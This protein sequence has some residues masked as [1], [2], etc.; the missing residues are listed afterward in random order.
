MHINA[1]G[2]CCRQWDPRQSRHEGAIHSQ[3]SLASLSGRTVLEQSQDAGWQLALHGEAGQTVNTWDTM[4]NHW[5][6]DYDD[7]L[8]P[9][10]V[11]ENATRL[12]ERFTYSDTSDLNQ[13]GRLVRHDD[14]AGSQ[15]I[16]SYSLSGQ[17]RSETRHFLAALD[18]PDWPDAVLEPGDGATTSYIHGPLQQVLIQ[19]DALGNQQSF[20]FNL[21]G[22][23]KR[24][25]LRLVD[26][27]ERPL[28]TDARYNAFGQIESQTAGNGVVSRCEYEHSTGRLS[29]LVA[30]RPGRSVLQD[31]R[32]DY[33]PVGN[34]LKIEDRS[35]P[36]S[37]FANQ[38]VEPVS[39][40]VYDSLY[41]LI[42]A[43]GREA[44]G[45]VLGPGLPELAP[46]PGDTS[47]LLNYRQHYDYDASGNL[48]EL[49]H[50]GQQSY[51]REMAVATDSN[52]AVP[53]P[54]DPL[55]AFDSNGNL[56][57]PGAGQP[58][59]WNARN[60]LHGTRQVS[61][62]NGEDDEEHYRYGGDGLRL[63]KVTRRLVA[64]RMQSC[65]TR[66]LPGLE[67]HARAG[68]SFVVIATQ[69]GRCAVRCLHWQ[70]GQPDGIASP[71]LRFSLDDHLGSSGLEVDGEARIISHEGYYPFGGTAWWA[72][73]SA[74]E[75]GYKIRRYSSKER[76]SSGLYD[77]G[78]RYYAPWLMRWINPDP[79]GDVD[80]LNRYRFVRNNPAT[81]VDPVGL[82]AE[83][84]L[85]TIK[86][87]SR[88]AMAPGSENFLALP[89]SP[90]L[91]LNVSG[92]V[93]EF[94]YDTLWSVRSYLNRGASNQIGDVLRSKY[95][96]F[97]YGNQMRAQLGSTPTTQDRAEHALAIQ[98][99]LC[100]E[101]A[102]VALLLMG[103]SARRPDTPIFWAMKP[104]H[105]FALINDPRQTDALVIDPWPIF[106][107]IHHL[108]Q[109]LDAPT[110]WTDFTPRMPTEPSYK[111]SRLTVNA[112]WE[113][114]YAGPVD[115]SPELRAEQLLQSI[116][117][118]FM[119][120]Q[121]SAM[122][123]PQSVTYMANGV[124]L[125]AASI[126]QPFWGPTLESYDYDQRNNLPAGARHR[127]RRL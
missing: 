97:I 58:L 52:R 98:G 81:R 59:Q 26:G 113:I 56:L 1:N 62:N 11:R 119:F 33:D 37:H 40:F 38:R 60:Q 69:A 121:L 100:D 54:G 72:A 84:T 106:P 124:E 48:L 34:V 83:D 99:G 31:L 4:G 96:S 103:S 87:F 82:N 2:Q 74:I 89:G 93:A 95:T 24:L 85:Y 104:G 115:L 20:H 9:M 16:D 49:R 29:R 78:L 45:A 55:K 21:S 64:G 112:L 114:H 88:Y 108:S 35:Q 109:S 28:L 123:D 107:A 120:S 7:L 65:Q 94:A 126:P 41:Q 25:V 22:E 70:E 3:Q 44:A 14:E 66:Y 117:G 76:D 90:G 111:L 102:A 30:S 63:R 53:A 61:R 75:A 50:I 116:T 77:Y 10:Q 13:R 27:K 67:L 17:V 51:T 42:E 91:Q 6:T 46:D 47:R 79:A 86:P 18:L 105:T 80:G 36:V 127:L 57:Q 125:N 19:T 12:A 43:T 68:E 92:Q 110:Q 71:Q 5:Q 73:R 101:F 23:L 118:G 8:R 32:Y 15:M 122:K 39:T